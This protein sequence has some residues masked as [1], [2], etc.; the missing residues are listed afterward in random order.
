MLG[1]LAILTGLLGFVGGAVLLMSA[2]PVVAGLSVYEILVGLA[3]VMTG[4]GFLEGLRWAWALGIV[5]SLLSLIWNG[6]EAATG[7]IVLAVPGLVIPLLILFYLT[8]P[9]VKSY[10]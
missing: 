10:F 2:D 8:R 3:Y 4:V 7:R 1:V 6:I 5:V 9:E